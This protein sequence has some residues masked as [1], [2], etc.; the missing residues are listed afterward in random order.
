M[1]AE[2]R[3]HHGDLRAAL[4]RAAQEILAEGGV[5]A[6]TLRE[7]ARRIGVSHAAPK[8]HFADK[9]ALLAAVAAQGYR[10]M[11]TA[12]DRER[13]EA[14]PDARAQ[15][16]AVGLGYIRFALAN[17]GTF[18]LMYGEHAV[19]HDDA[20]LRTAAQTVF[21]RL[22][23]A[24]AAVERAHGRDPA[25]DAAVQRRMLA[26]TVVHGFATLWLAGG[27]QRAFGVP[28]EVQAAL[29]TA[30]RFLTATG[31]GIP[32]ADPDRGRNDNGGDP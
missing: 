15:L 16:R 17:P 14:P 8:H 30:E 21:D 28:A 3:Y 6:L 23:D 18:R 11:A 26:W 5:G 29:D 31:P 10:D 27:L 19:A 22:A 24:A 4:I 32:D 2:R 7:C 13:A 25:G 1:P 9:T 12:M 20:A